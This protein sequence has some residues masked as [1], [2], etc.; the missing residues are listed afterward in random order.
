MA[1]KLADAQMAGVPDNWIVTTVTEVPTTPGSTPVRRQLQQ[2]SPPASGQGSDLQLVSRIAT[3]Q[4]TDAQNQ[5]RGAVNSGSL[6]QQMSG[7]GWK[8][9]P[10]TASYEVGHCVK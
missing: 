10:Q 6:P 7:F 5:L 4:P 1:N 3:N 9:V 8:Y 2:Q